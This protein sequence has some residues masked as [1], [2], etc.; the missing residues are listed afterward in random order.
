M[1]NGHGGARPGAGRPKGSKGKR[2]IALEERLRELGG[3]PFAVLVD[4]C[5]GGEDERI[6]VDAAKALLP[7]LYPRLAS[8]DLN[9]TGE[10]LQNVILE[11]AKSDDASDG[12]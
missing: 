11:I 2:T 7:Y 3:D 12:D 6:R 8:Q 1:S 4:I 5:S 9:V 10:T